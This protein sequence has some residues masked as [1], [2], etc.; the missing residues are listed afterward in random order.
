[1][2]PPAALGRY[3]DACAT[4][5]PAPEVRQAMWQAEDQA[6]ANPSS[7]HGFGIAAAES[8]ERS[9]CELAAGFGCAPEELVFCSG[10]TE[11]IHMA[12]LGSAAR[13]EPG[14]LLISAVEHPATVAAAAQLAH[15]GW[16]VV[17]LPVD[18]RGVLRL[19]A[20]EPLLA[21]PTRLVSVIWGQSEVGAIPPIPARG[22][23]CRRAGIPLHVDAVQVVGHQPLRFDSLPVDLLSCTAHKLQGPRGIGALLV[24]AGRELDPLIG[25]G[26]Q[27]SGRRGGTEPVL[28]AAG[29]AAA[30]ELAQA[31]LGSHQGQDQDPL[32]T[33]RDRL[34]ERLLALPGVRLTGPSP[35]DP[36]GRLPH[37][38]SLLVE[39]SDGQP[40]PGRALVRQLWRQGFAVSSG[41]ACQTGGPG[42]GA[43]AVLL[44]MGYGPL[45][46][47]GGLR[48][49]LGPWV[50]AD[51]LAAFPEALVQAR[52]ALLSQ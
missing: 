33:D 49:S 7:L 11:A 43:S 23:L 22:D 16:E 8:L 28:L 37:H 31:R 20:V 32:A 18:R 15:R 42:T 48:I 41:S 27:E 39:G 46:A 45:E 1:M 50:E 34:L 40:L 9:R 10:A 35:D 17:S 52:Q 30:L 14:R 21:T 44:A 2:T 4:S 13:M 24:R 6:W 47:A 38:I 29:F 51:A 36:Q 26:G 19:E 25:G 12:L 3:L 5:P